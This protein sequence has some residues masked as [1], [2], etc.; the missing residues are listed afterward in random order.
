MSDQLDPVVM[1]SFNRLWQLVDV[2][3]TP[4]DPAALLLGAE[5]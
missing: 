4:D 1:E 5:I 2:A 3:G